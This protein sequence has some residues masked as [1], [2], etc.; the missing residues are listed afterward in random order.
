LST[1]DIDDGPKQREAARSERSLLFDA[2]IR[3]ATWSSEEGPGGVALIR[4][5]R[6]IELGIED[7][8]SLDV[9]APS[10]VFDALVVGLER[11]SQVA[12][13]VVAAA[14]ELYQETLGGFRPPGRNHFY[15]LADSK[16]PIAKLELLE[17]GVTVSLE[18]VL[19]EEIELAAETHGADDSSSELDS[20]ARAF[21]TGVDRVVREIR[22]LG[23]LIGLAAAA[24][25]LLL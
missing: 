21:A 25:I 19:V 14:D 11:D 15:M 4:W 24:L 16:N 5:D 8:W 23:T 2:E 20:V 3:R 17:V 7:S 10:D 12:A 1:L 9:E 18:R 22:F 6:D 13:T